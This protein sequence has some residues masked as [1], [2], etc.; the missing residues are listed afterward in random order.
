MQVM[1]T[2][3]G[4]QNLQKQATLPNRKHHTAPVH[5]PQYVR[6]SATSVKSTPRPGRRNG[7]RRCL[8]R[9]TH[10][11]PR[12]RVPFRGHV[13]CEQRDPLKRYRCSS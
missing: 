5:L 6:F 2:L 7:Q 3:V 12:E 10:L 8:A 1:P 9:W 11:E 4:S 13:I